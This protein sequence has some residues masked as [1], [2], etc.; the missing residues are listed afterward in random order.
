MTI[1]TSPELTILFDDSDESG[2]DQSSTPVWAIPT[3]WS[4]LAIV[5]PQSYPHRKP[6]FRPEEAEPI[7][8]KNITDIFICEGVCPCILYRVSSDIGGLTSQFG[9][10]S[11]ILVVEGF[12]LYIEQ[13]FS[14]KGGLLSPIF[15]LGTRLTTRLRRERF[16]TASANLVC[17]VCHGE[18]WI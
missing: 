18:R 3:T 6:S 1:P 8:L 14:Y 2:I 4:P 17:F 7:S 11:G 12:P 13:V 9:G 10:S 5:V 15:G 16:T